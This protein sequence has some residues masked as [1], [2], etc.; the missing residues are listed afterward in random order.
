MANKMNIVTNHHFRD[1]TYGYELT[2][3]ERAEFDHYDDD[4]IYAHGFVRY[5]GEVLDLSDFVKMP[6]QIA[7]D[8]PEV[9]VYHGFRSDS[10]FSGTLVRYNQDYNM[11]EVATYLI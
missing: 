7:L 8:H 9:K 5:K 10:Y 4:E 3:A 6:N 2:D 11:V 1:I